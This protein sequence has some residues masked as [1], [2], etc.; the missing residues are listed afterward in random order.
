MITI[1]SATLVWV[2]LVTA[3]VT[4]QHQI[5]L[6]QLVEATIP[7]CDGTEDCAAKWNAARTWVMQH[8]GYKIQT[9]TDVVIQT[10][11]AVDSS[12]RALMATVRKESIGAG[13]Y[14][15][16]AQLSCRNMFGCA[17]NPGKATLNFNRTV[18]ATAP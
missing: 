13:K 3:C 15:I 17:T 11:E 9:T 12:D 2:L 10:F 18:A 1:R 6:Q 14:R 5:E 4:P 16:V 7:T 8:A